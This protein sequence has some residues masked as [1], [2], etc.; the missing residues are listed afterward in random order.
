MKRQI[1]ERQ[2]KMKEEA[3]YH[4]RGVA[5]MQFRDEK[6]ESVE[7]RQLEKNEVIAKVREHGVWKGW[8][9]PANRLPDL[10]GSHLTAAIEL[11]KEMVM[12][13]VFNTVDHTIKYKPSDFDLAIEH[14]TQE[15]CNEDVGTYARFWE[16]VPEQTDTVKSVY[17][18][19]EETYN[20]GDE[21][22]ES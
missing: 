22:H 1:R 7:Y 5:R 20:R 9:T 21:E 19:S 17:M 15:F 8:M 12:E 4:E 11:T 10:R 18:V 2:L 14:F 13:W 16:A 3:A 6:A